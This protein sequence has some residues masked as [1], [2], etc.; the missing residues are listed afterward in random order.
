M[1][2]YR[3]VFTESARENIF[4]SYEWGCREWGKEAAQ[5]WA[6]DLRSSVEKFCKYFL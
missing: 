5:Q 3:I 1:K 6:K 2:P 4:E